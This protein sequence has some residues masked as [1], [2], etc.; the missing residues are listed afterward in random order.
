MAPASSSA[1]T[2]NNNNEKIESATSSSSSSSSVLTETSSTNNNKDDELQ[3]QRLQLYYEQAFR[4]GGDDDDLPLQTF[5][6]LPYWNTTNHEKFRVVFILGGPGA[7]KGTQSALMAENYP[8][9]VHLSVGQL[10]REE[11]SKPNSPHREL[12]EQALVSGSIVP[13][14]ISLALVKQAMQQATTTTTRPGGASEDKNNNNSKKDVLFLIDGFPR[15]DDN[16][17]GWCQYMGNVAAVWAVLFYT[18]PLQVLE[19]RL[20]DRA[21]NSG[22]SDDNLKSIHKR[23]ATFE[24][25]TVPIIRQLQALSKMS[26]STS[27]GTPFP[28][29]RP[30]WCVWEIA[31]DQTLD[32]VWLATQHALNQL[33]RHDVLTA[34]AQLLQAVE[35]GDSLAY[36]ELCDPLWFAN[37]SS[38]T[39]EQSTLAGGESA[40]DDDD[41]DSLATA[42]AV[43]EQYEGKPTDENN[44]N[45]LSCLSDAELEFISGQHVAVSYTRLLGRQLVREKRL[46]VYNNKNSE[47]GEHGP[48]D[49]TSIIS[50]HSGWRNVHFSRTPVMPDQPN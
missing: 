44:R 32:Q 9:V 35:Q 19:Q 6:G 26:S 27:T 18:C 28:R 5:G 14:E 15:N 16:L 17:A 39:T 47:H 24:Q 49:T 46:W 4:L 8:N 25:E 34:N 30:Q 13:V 48:S 37:H 42:R 45:I 36:Q 7:G 38:T 22:R 40:N 20:L 43:M 2:S 10:L 33:I 1:E 23:F 31:G 50:H 29:P 11:Q 41:E 3:K 12:I 21:Q